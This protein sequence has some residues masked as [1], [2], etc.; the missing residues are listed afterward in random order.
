MSDYIIN[1]NPTFMQNE[2]MKINANN[3]AKVTFDEKVY[4]DTKLKP[5]EKRRELII[6]ILP[7]S[8]DC[9]DLWAEVKVHNLKV[10]KKINQSGFKSYT[11]LN[12]EKGDRY[13][14]ICA[15]GSQI[16]AKAQ[17]AK[18]QGNL[19]LQKA[20]ELEAKKLFTRDAY[21]IRCIER[22]KE[23]E[24]IKFWR[25]YGSAKGDGIK[26]NIMALDSSIKD[27]MA[28]NGKP[29]YN[30]F[31][32][33]N[34]RDLKLILTEGMANNGKPITNI[35]IMP[36]MT[37]S[38]L[39]TDINQANIWLSDGKTWKDVYSTKSPE[40]LQ[41]IVDGQ[42][43]VKDKET[44]KYVGRDINENVYNPQNIVPPTPQPSNMQQN[45]VMGNP[46]QAYQQNAGVYQQQNM[47]QPSYVA[48]AP[49]YQQPQPNTNGNGGNG[50]SK[51]PF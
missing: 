3:Q 14:P 32:L 22:G 17:E 51:L 19:E 47:Q 23:H 9:S 13:C 48:P 36:S 10:D 11:C 46:S 12:K 30:M 27:E 41:I 49:N 25:F 50:M 40:Y 37:E 31:D 42:I 6:R 29:G 24:G 33:N 20:L 26:D 8:N 5:G 43:P 35:T 45:A 34:G 1:T 38:P 7:I 15:K 4:L 16:W 28:R 2:S 39:S 21:I 44:G 18:V